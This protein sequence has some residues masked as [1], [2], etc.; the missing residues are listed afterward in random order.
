MPKL[1]SKINS[2]Q[3]KYL[4]GITAK[5]EALICAIGEKAQLELPKFIEDFYNWLSNL[6]ERE[7]FSAL[8]AALNKIRLQQLEYWRTFFSGKICANYLENLYALG[9]TYTEISL[10]TYLYVAFVNFSTQWWLNFI[11]KLDIENNELE[12]SELALIKML[13]LEASI[14]NTAFA[15]FYKELNKKLEKSNHYKSEFLANMSHELRTP[16]NSIMVLSQILSE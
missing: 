15:D 6:P 4:F 12:F 2:E 3:V 9:R 16:L 1:N 13:N 11:R 7:E 8:I 14:V 5:D 10:P